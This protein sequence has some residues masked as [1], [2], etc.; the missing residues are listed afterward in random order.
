MILSKGFARVTGTPERILQT[1][2]HMRAE[3]LKRIEEERR[4]FPGVGKIY[5]YLRKLEDESP[6]EFIQFAARWA[7]NNLLAMNLTGRIDESPYTEK[8]YQLG[9]RLY[10]LEDLIRAQEEIKNSSNTAKNSA[11]L[12]ADGP[13]TTQEAR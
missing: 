2:H 7:V 10:H 1:L 13:Q 4:P 9:A 3:T 8:S 12:I 6:R 11:I 5:T